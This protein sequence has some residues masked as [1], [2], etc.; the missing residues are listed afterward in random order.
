MG[1]HVVGWKP[2][3]PP[4]TLTSCRLVHLEGKTARA[5]RSGCS[6]TRGPSGDGLLGGLHA[7]AVDADDDRVDERVLVVVAVVLAVTL[8]P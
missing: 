6:W 8:V 4:A 7:L 5:P 3:M 2:R 1:G